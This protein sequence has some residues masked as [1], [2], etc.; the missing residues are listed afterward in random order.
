MKTSFIKAIRPQSVSLIFSVWV[1]GLVLGISLWQPLTAQTITGGTTKLCPGKGGR[2]FYTGGVQYLVP[3]QPP[4][5]PKTNTLYLVA[6]GA[7]FNT[8]IQV[9][10]VRQPVVSSGEGPLGRIDIQIPDNLPP[11]LIGKPVN[12]RFS[13]KDANAKRTYII[14]LA[15][16]Q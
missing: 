15:N 6:V 5:S 4:P 14:D 7:P 8:G 1:A 13:E 16:C 12:L 3:G 10:S 9:G 11:D 2:I